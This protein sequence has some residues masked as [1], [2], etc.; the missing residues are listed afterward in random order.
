MIYFEL[1]NKVSSQVS[2]L[3]SVCERERE[4]ESEMR[5][6]E[7]SDGYFTLYSKVQYSKVQ[8][9]NSKGDEI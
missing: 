8:Y 6:K 7:G 3:R 2:V 5:V 4:R 9:S 1:G